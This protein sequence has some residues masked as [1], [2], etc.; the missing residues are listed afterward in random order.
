M[1]E[2]YT[3]YILQDLFLMY[4]PSLLHQHNLHVSLMGNYSRGEVRVDVF[5]ES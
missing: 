1:C 2:L 5:N 3:S 4:R